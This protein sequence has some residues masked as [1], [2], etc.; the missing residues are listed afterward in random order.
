MQAIVDPNELQQHELFNQARLVASQTSR[1]HDAN[2]YKS[3]DELLWQWHLWFDGGREVIS[4]VFDRASRAWAIGPPVPLVS[5]TTDEGVDD[6]LAHLLSSTAFFREKPKALGVVLHVADEFGLA[7]LSKRSEMFGEDGGDV[8]ILRYGLIDDPS[9]VLA[10]KDGSLELNTWR[11]LPITGASSGADQCVALSLSRN[12]E[13]FLKKLIAGGEERGVPVRVSVACAAVEAFAALPWLKP[14]L[15]GACLVAICYHKFTAVFALNQS[16]ELCAVRSFSHR[17]GLL[18]PSSFGDILWNMS[19]GAEMTNLNV[20]V[21]SDKKP[22]LQS[23]AQE[24]EAFSASRQQA[25]FEL[26]CLEDQTAFECL[27]SRRPEFIIYDS[28]G[29]EQFLKAGPPLVRSDTFKELL[30]TWAKQNFM[31]TARLDE[32]YPTRQDLRLLRLSK[33]FTNMLLL[34][35]IGMFLYGI[36][37]FYDATGKPS[38]VLTQEQVRQTESKHK[39]LIEE[40]RQMDLAESFLKPRSR[41]W[42][43]MELLLQL[44]PEESGVRLENFNYNIETSRVASANSKSTPQSFA[45]LNRTWKLK[46]LAKAQSLQALNN[47]N[48]QDGLN[49][50]FKRIS[51][52]TGEKALNPQPS[53]QLVI[54]LTQGR[55]SQFNAQASAA[56]IAADPAISFPFSFEAT[57][58]QAISEKD[59]FALPIDK[60]F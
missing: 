24:L 52:L 21:I 47:L 48:S 20:L 5:F 13:A 37:S 35:V 33:W 7:E 18:Y 43:N 10:N 29:V 38:W 36:M 55:N 11:P 26:L 14:R 19:L 60:I 22:V 42:V 28:A 15:D 39:K 27:P 8:Q 12:R 50:F 9:E 57:I 40:K 44:F 58:T 6:I 49:E 53:R 17:A 3:A 2:W 34:A 51:I 25:S 46:G 54:S 56:E 59:D 32:L 4:V 45:G 1:S 30:A 31:N 23:V 16:G 41:G